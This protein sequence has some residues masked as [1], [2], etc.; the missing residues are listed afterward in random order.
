MVLNRPVVL[1]MARLTKECDLAAEQI[2][3]FVCSTQGD[4]VPPY[5]ARTFC[6]WLFD[7]SE[8]G[9]LSQTCF[10]VCALGDRYVHRQ[11][12]PTAMW[13]YRSYAHFCRCGK[14]VAKAMKQN[15]AHEFVPSVKVDKEDW[16][17]I[18]KWIAEV[19][20]ALPSLNLNASRIPFQGIYFT[21]RFVKLRDRCV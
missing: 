9:D 14:R 17:V 8:I 20:T 21:P 3:L 5:E 11:L 12:Q 18:H 1:N 2:L 19:M 13:S 16:T 6:E 4:G 10:S 15:G 7:G